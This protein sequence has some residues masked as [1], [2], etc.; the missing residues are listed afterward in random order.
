MHVE[1]RQR[2]TRRRQ[3]EVDEMR[4]NGNDHTNVIDNTFAQG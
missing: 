4:M 3:G 1:G 2:Q